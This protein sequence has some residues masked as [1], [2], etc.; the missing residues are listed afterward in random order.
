MMQKAVVNLYL[1]LSGF[2]LHLIHLNL[3][4]MYVCKCL[5]GLNYIFFVFME[6][7]HVIEKC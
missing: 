3:H 6:N 4:R 2:F 7:R 1:I 5:V